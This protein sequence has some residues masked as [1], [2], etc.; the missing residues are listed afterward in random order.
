MRYLSSGRT[1]LFW[2]SEFRFV[3]LSARKEGRVREVGWI[4]LFVVVVQVF[5]EEFVRKLPDL[6][7][8][9]EAF[10]IIMSMGGVALK[11]HTRTRN[12]TLMGPENEG[13]AYHQ[14]TRKYEP[15]SNVGE[16]AAVSSFHSKTGSPR[17]R[18][19]SS[20]R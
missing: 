14:V 10:L 2:G 19:S 15:T 16:Q 18:W 11:P 5:D 1:Y 3:A 7:V 8:S 9:P 20:G 17:A 13:L 4:I 6:G 12:H